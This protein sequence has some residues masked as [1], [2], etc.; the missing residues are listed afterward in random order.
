[1]VLPEA[2]RERAAEGLGEIDIFFDEWGGFV[3]EKV[4]ESKYRR[5]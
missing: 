4:N 1:M 3:S 2:S 5:R